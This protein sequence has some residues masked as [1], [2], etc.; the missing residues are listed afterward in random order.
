MEIAKVVNDSHMTSC[1]YN[2]NNNNNNTGGS[3]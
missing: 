3:S 2:N 1:D